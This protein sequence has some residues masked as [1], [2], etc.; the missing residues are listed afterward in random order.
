[1]FTE[2][3]GSKDASRFLQRQPHASSEQTLAL[4]E[5]WGEKNWHHSN[6]FIWT[7]CRTDGQAIGLFLMFIDNDSAEIHFGIGPS[8]WGN[9]LV[10]EAGKAV[11]DWVE[12][13][14]PLSAVTTCCAADHA[15]SL[16]VLE[17]I[18]LQHT[19]HLPAYLRL[20][21]GDQK[22]DAWVCRWKRLKSDN[23]K[24]NML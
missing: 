11:M 4:L 3:T 19:R 13:S 12:K 10:T 21:A 15:A 24:R 7:I 5:K 2:Y 8:W 1:V 23:P 22:V 6:R 20:A 17:K 18:G 16:K 14:S 9:G